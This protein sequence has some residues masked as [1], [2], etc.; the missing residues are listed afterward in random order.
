MLFRSGQAQGAKNLIDQNDIKKI[1]KK[2]VSYKIQLSNKIAKEKIEQEQ[3]LKSLNDT[4]TT[5][6]L[7]KEEEII[8]KNQLLA[9]EVQSK[10]Q[11]AL[12][13][14]M[15]EELRIQKEQEIERLREQL[16][17]KDE[18]L[19]VKESEVHNKSAEKNRIIE[20]M[21]NNLLTNEE[22]LKS[23]HDTLSTRGNAITKKNRVIVRKDKLISDKDQE[24]EIGRAHV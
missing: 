23:L 5:T 20:D 8:T 6:L 22:E 2:L 4:F 3:E 13:K 7:T 19:L 15:E 17:Q 24:I 14:E 12:Q 18:L 1:S 9:Q 21:A 10:N 11:L 16:A